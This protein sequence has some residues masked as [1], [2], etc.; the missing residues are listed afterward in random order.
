MKTYY[1]SLDFMKFIMAL[2][3]IMI[4]VSLF[5]DSNHTLFLLT[6][7]GVCRIAVPF[8]FVLTGYF[9][10]MHKQLKKNIAHY[11][12]WLIECL[13]LESIAFLPQIITEYHQGVFFRYFFRHLTSGFSGAL[14]YLTSSILGLIVLHFFISRSSYILP[15]LIGLCLWFVGL[16]MDSYAGFFH[17]VPFTTIAKMHMHIFNL[18]QAGL[19]TSLVYMSTGAMLHHYQIDMKYKKIFFILAVMCLE[20]EAYFLNTYAIAYDGNIYV[21]LLFCGPLL[22][23]IVKDSKIKLNTAFAKACGQYSMYFYFIHPSVIHLLRG[24]SMTSF[25]CFVIVLCI[26]YVCSYVCVHYCA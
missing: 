20:L 19:L 9:Y 21:S 15:F 23:I 13:I 18:P 22:F 7:M 17:F 26:T 25:I 1:P 10:D 8:F 6:V 24:F 12:L 14:W 3:V 5:Q 11:S 4:H 16:S 2:S